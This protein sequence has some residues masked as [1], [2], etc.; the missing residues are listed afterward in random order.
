MVIL[1]GW[2]R[3]RAKVKTYLKSYSRAGSIFENRFFIG[4]NSPLL[5]MIL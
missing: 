4:K 2:Q 1:F 3:I 5:L